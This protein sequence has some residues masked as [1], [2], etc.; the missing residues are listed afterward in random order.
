MKFEVNKQL[1]SFTDLIS[2]LRSE[3]GNKLQQKKFKS[4]NKFRRESLWNVRQE[5]KDM[6]P[7]ELLKKLLKDNLR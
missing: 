2:E 7:Q 4:M 5:Q 3:A 1:K 6:L